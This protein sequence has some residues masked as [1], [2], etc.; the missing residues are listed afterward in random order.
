MLQAEREN[1]R[2]KF[3]LSVS[4]L[5]ACLGLRERVRAKAEYANMSGLTLSQAMPVSH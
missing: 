2:A 4:L 3:S 1:A 5:V